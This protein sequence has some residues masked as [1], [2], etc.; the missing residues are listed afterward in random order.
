MP[1]LDRYVKCHDCNVVHLPELDKDR[2]VYIIHQSKEERYLI[3]HAASY[4]EKVK[5]VGIKRKSGRHNHESR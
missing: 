4:F 3:K 5:V 1:R 2:I